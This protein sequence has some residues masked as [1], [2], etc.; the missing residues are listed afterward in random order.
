MVNVVFIFIYFFIYYEDFDELDVTKTH[1]PVAN[2]TRVIDVCQQL[3]RRSVD[4]L[5]GQYSLRL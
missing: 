5:K 3:V 2:L 4:T 1:E